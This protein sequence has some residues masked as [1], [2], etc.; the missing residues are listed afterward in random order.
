MQ[1]KIEFKPKSFKDLKKIPK[2]QRKSIVEKIEGLENNLAGDV[3]KMT[4]FSPEY[5]LRIG[6]YRVL[7]EIENNSVVIYRIRH[8]KDIYR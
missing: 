4:N 2:H 3:K 7:F 5:R 1:F 8:R 6:K